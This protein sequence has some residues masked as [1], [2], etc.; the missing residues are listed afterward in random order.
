[1]APGK[2]PFPAAVAF[3]ARVRQRRQ[4][5]DLTLEGLA[6]LA[7]LD[8]TYVGQVERGKRNLSLLNLLRLAKALGVDPS[9]LVVGLDPGGSGK[10]NPRR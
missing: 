8:W 1:M 2:A 9:E 10:S 3:G 5:R 4:D 6:E 7:G